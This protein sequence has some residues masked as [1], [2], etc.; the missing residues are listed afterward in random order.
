MPQG[1]L[2]I[3]KFQ[4]GTKEVWSVKTPPWNIKAIVEYS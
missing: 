4:A 1:K 3:V 2:E